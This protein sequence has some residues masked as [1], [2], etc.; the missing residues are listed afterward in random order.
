MKGLSKSRGASWSAVAVIP[1]SERERPA[2]VYSL[3]QANALRKR[4]PP[5]AFGVVAALQD[6]SDLRLIYSIS[7]PPRALRRQIPRG[8]RRRAR[9]GRGPFRK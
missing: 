3:S 5:K 1:L 9:R 7:T 2:K 6:A 4:R 8:P